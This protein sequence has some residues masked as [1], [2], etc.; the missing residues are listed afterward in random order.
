MFLCIFMYLCFY[1]FMFLC[2]YRDTRY[3]RYL[4]FRERVSGFTGTNI[5]K[6]DSSTILQQNCNLIV[7]QIPKDAI[8][9]QVSDDRGYV[10]KPWIRPLVK[11]TS[12]AFV[13]PEV[14]H[15]LIADKTSAKSLCFEKSKHCLS[16]T[17]C[18]GFP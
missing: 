5:G 14:K 9:L 17:I 11:E 6:T 7:R 1:V 12:F 8:S 15:I 2:F 16:V 3:D 4:L 10:S 13:D 18:A